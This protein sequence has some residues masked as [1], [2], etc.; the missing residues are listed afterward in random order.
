MRRISKMV[1][2]LTAALAMAVGI[3][4]GFASPT[5]AATC[6]VTFNRYSEVTKGSSGAKAKAAQCLLR[7][8]G[9]AV[10]ADG[11]FSGADT[12][13]LKKFQRST[14]LRASGT[15]TRRSWTALL[16]RG[17]R[18]RL[19]SGDRGDSVRRLQRALTAAGRQVPATGYFGSATE[20]AVRA[21]QHSGGLTVTGVA[22]KTVWR[23][24]QKG[25]TI[26]ASLGAS[27]TGE[28]TSTSKGQRALAFAKRQ[29][30]DRYRF[31]AA[32]PNAW[33]CSGLTAGAWKAAGVNLPHNSRAQFRRGK[34]VSRSDLRPGDLVFFYSPIS[35]V[36]IYAGNGEVVQASRPSKPVNVGRVSDM[37]FA[38]ARRVG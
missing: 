20:S 6:D 13:A 22:T 4:I 26:E 36:A 14:G 32:G 2:S 24:L 17:T 21:F 29:L 30:G 1:A 38:G 19:D 34:K 3:T 27:S 33:D 8:A 11:S 28:R 31:G 37:P 15:M 9:Y 5:A 23:G 18:P 35:H 25:R 16:S 12:A 7:S 10:R